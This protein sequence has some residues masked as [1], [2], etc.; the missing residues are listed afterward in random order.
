MF[1]RHLLWTTHVNLAP[2][3][4]VIAGGVGTSLPARPAVGSILHRDNHKRKTNRCWL[5]L[6]AVRASGETAC[7]W[8]C[9]FRP[10][11]TPA[12][13]HEPKLF[14][15]SSS[16]FCTMSVILG[17]GPKSGR[18]AYHSWTGGKREGASA[19]FAEVGV[20]A[21]SRAILQGLGV[22]VSSGCTC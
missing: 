11:L 9:L 17:L 10:T 4:G 3:T 13:A 18:D 5:L 1:L 6:P 20:H 22:E 7:P 2:T 8:T 16:P 14:C 21:T 19:G 15:F 12:T